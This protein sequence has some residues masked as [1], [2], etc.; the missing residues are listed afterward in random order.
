MV[1][2]E[3]RKVCRGLCPVALCRQC[4][5]DWKFG[6]NPK[7]NWVLF[8]FFLNTYL[9]TQSERSQVDTEAVRERQGSSLP[10]VQGAQCRTRLQ[11]PEIM[12]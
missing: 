3:A 4:S 12:T 1:G 2:H 11:D 7:R 6:C 9:L 5:S 10:A 8:L